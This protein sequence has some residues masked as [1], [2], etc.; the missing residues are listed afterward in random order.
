MSN[1]D[2]INEITNAITELDKA[3]VEVIAEIKTL[4]DSLDEMK[5]NRELLVSTL[6]DL[7]SNL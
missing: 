2:E 5:I 4:T 7:V 6:K 1:I 3:L